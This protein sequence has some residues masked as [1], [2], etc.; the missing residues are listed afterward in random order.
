LV[1]LRVPFCLRE[2]LLLVLAEI[3]D[4]EWFELKES[5]DDVVRWFWGAR[6]EGVGWFADVVGGIGGVGGIGVL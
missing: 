1:T 4:V 3:V 5:F 6:R 2:K